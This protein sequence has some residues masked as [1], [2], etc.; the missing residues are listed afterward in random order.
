MKK[1]STQGYERDKET[2][3]LI[4]PEVSGQKLTDEQA[5]QLGEALD[6]ITSEEATF[7]SN[8]GV[9]EHEMEYIDPSTVEG[10][11]VLAITDPNTGLT[12][13]VPVKPTMEDMEMAELLN[14]PV[15]DLINMPTSIEEIDIKDEYYEKN[16]KEATFH[17][18]EGD[19]PEIIELVKEYRKNPKQDWLSKFPKCLINEID[20][21]CKETN[22]FNMPYRKWIA[23]QFLQEIVV[24]SGMDKVIIDMQSQ[25]QKVFDTESK[26]MK[27]AIDFCETEMETAIDKKIAAANKLIEDFEEKRIIKENELMLAKDQNN[28]EYI[29]QID[30]EI[31][32]LEK[33]LTTCR[34]QIENFNKLKAQVRESYMLTDLL[35]QVQSGKIKVKPKHTEKYK[36]H[37]QEFLFKYRDISSKGTPYKI[38]D[39]SICV[40]ILVRLLPMFTA[41]QLGNTIIA[42][43][44][45]TK[46]YSSRNVYEHAYMYFFIR[47]IKNLSMT[48]KLGDENITEFTKVLLTNIFKITCA[49]N[50][51]DESELQEDLE[52]ALTSVQAADKNL[53]DKET[54]SAPTEEERKALMKK[55]EDD[56]KKRAQ[57]LKLGS[58]IKASMSNQPVSAFQNPAFRPRKK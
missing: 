12:S 13:T 31:K 10:E 27:M 37:C 6:E 20:K 45:Q 47:N 39:I 46:N 17:V 54:K 25:L 50:K 38:D 21:I 53:T 43:T 28:E 7:P 58:A 19:I 52:A 2:K 42:F 33:K 15:D 55:M 4:V 35:E 40:P 23:T 57:A 41:R 3:E 30:S 8:N 14:V 24:S 16:L 29:V 22:N 1:L 34:N 5:N 32:E 56:K 26:F 44:M 51:L 11:E 49:V 9:L 36:R 48:L 18:E